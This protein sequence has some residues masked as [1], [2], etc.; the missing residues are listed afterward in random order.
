MHLARRGALR[1]LLIGSLGTVWTACRHAVDQHGGVLI[2]TLVSAEQIRIARE[3]AATAPAEETSAAPDRPP[4]A[5][6][7][8]Q[9]TIASSPPERS[10]WPS[11]TRGA[12]GILV[13][14]PITRFYET[15]YRTSN[16][17]PELNPEEWQLT[18][19]GWVQYP[20]TL[21]LQG[22]LRLPQVEAMRTL[23]CISNPVGGT[24]IGNTVWRGVRLAD[25]LTRAGI[26]PGARELRMTA[27]DG[28][29][30]SIPLDLAMSSDSLLAFEMDGAPLPVKHGYPMRVLLPGRYGQKQ[31]KW[32][33][34][35][36]VTPDISLGYW[37]S[38]GWSNEAAVRVNS[39]IWAPAALSLIQGDTVE[40]FGIAFADASGVAGVEVSTNGGVSW[41]PADLVTG[42]TSLVWTEWRY[43]WPVPA[44][45]SAT[46]VTVAVRATDGNGV[47]QRDE[48]EETGVL[49][50]TYPDGTTNIHRIVVTVQT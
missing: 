3:Q 19:D 12:D 7:P 15:R 39:Q 29:Q 40:I 36:E 48:V 47:T 10:P 35:L 34:R 6:P 8:A 24:L 37:E 22:L 2:P 30:T 13:T 16:P 20:E 50:S 44:S 23:E 17:R 41:E 21:D 27:A 9:P 31:P 28:Y 26:R 43:N 49:G 33:T 46:P 45:V 42:P 5:S 32:I 25:V 14:S 18:I 1:A 4:T 38:R 11:V